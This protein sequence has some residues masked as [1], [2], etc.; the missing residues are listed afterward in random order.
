MKT[1]G[2]DACLFDPDE[3]TGVQA[4]ALVLQGASATRKTT[5]PRKG[6]LDWVEGMLYQDT[7]HYIP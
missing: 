1:I 2:K 5:L 4:W 6:A 7:F 3:E